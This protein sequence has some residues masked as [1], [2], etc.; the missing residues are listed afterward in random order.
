[1]QAHRRPLLWNA[2]DHRCMGDGFGC[3]DTTD[4]T[5]ADTSGCQDA[6][7]TRLDG[8]LCGFP[9]DG[10]LA[11]VAMSTSPDPGVNAYSIDR[12]TAMPVRQSQ[13]AWRGPAGQLGGSLRNVR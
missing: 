11:A 12:S 10:C 6:G 1:M 7:S 13:R 9:D 2:L 4:G 3:L 5:G 8:G